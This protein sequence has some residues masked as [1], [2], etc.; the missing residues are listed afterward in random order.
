MLREVYPLCVVGLTYIV[1]IDYRRN[2]LLNFVVEVK[3]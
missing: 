3:F 2:M 1:V